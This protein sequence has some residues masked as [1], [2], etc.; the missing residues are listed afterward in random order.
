MRLGLLLRVVVEM[1]PCLGSKLGRALG[2]GWCWS[3]YQAVDGVH[4]DRT[5]DRRGR[6]KSHYWRGA[7][8]GAESAI[9]VR[10][11]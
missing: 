4:G 2:R 7:G 5:A 10:A 11:R 6:S 3:V 1:K 9:T 8:P